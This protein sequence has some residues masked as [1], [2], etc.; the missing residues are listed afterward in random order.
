DYINL[1][2]PKNRKKF[3]QYPKV[4]LYRNS[5]FIMLTSISAVSTSF[6]F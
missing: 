1:A 3:K 4:P 6:I 2:I 5:F